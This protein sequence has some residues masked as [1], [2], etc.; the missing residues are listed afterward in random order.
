MPGQTIDELRAFNHF[1][2]EKL[3][4]GSGEISPEEAL[5][6]WRQLHPQQPDLEDNLAAIREALED[7]A[8]GDKGMPFNEFDRNFRTRHNFPAQQ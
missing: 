8:L 6:E 5:D 4:Q 1:L 3:T 7:Q 2:A